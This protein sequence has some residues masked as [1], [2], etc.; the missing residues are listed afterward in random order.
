MSGFLHQINYLGAAA[1]FS[2]GL[3]I[4]LIQGNLIRKIIGINLM[5]TAVFLVFVTIGYVRGARAPVIAESSDLN[6]AFIYVNPLPSALILT[7]IVVAV[8]ITVYALSLVLRIHRLYG[9]IEM[10][11]ILQIRENETGE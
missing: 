9:T 11:E 8:S 6:S 3:Y 7:G 4:V 2:I 10:E 1:L 5:E